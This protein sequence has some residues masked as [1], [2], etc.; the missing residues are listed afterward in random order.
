MVFPFISSVL[1]IVAYSTAIAALMRP[2]EHGALLLFSAAMPV[3]RSPLEHKSSMALQRAG[4]QS[5]HTR[6]HAIVRRFL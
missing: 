4:F 2:E 1:L 6:G 5:E 3:A